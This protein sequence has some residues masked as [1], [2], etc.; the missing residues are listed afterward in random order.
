MKVDKIEFNDNKN[1]NAQAALA[2]ITLKMLARSTGKYNM[3][4]DA[5]MYINEL[6]EVVY[7]EGKKGLN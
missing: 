3:V 5:V 2:N 4:N 7:E 6:L 1:I